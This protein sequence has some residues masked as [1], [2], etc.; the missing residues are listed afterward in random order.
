MMGDD[1]RRCPKCSR[2][3]DDE[4]DTL[5]HTDDC[6]WSGMSWADFTAAVDGGSLA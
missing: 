2:Y 3:V 4:T 5:D 1:P 6:P